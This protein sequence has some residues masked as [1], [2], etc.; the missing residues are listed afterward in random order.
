MH[1]IKLFSALALIS[2]LCLTV[3]GQTVYFGYD[4]AGNR[5]SRSITLQK[6]TAQSENENQPQPQEFKD[7]LGNHEVLIYPN[8]VTSELTVKIPSLGDNEY[9][10]ISLF[11]QN[12]R[13]VYRNERA[14]AFNVIGF[15]NLN[16]GVYYMKI[17]M[18]DRSVEWKVVKE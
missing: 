7:Q 2:L 5:I 12:G 8:P 18:K 11:D 1:T 16:A 9:T 4:A 15:S 13:M 14:T 17:M 6:S 3:S 10:I